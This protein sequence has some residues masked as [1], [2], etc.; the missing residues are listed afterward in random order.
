[1]PTQQDLFCK[2]SVFRRYSSASPVNGISR[3]LLAVVSNIVQ[4]ELPV[5]D[6]LLP[7]VD[8]P[9]CSADMAYCCDPRLQKA[10]SPVCR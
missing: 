6:F 10:V 8:G 5:A 2:S 9:T 4:G 7:L 3:D 1:M